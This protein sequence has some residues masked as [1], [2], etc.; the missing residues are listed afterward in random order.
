M[1][2]LEKEG[3][4]ARRLRALEEE[5]RLVRQS[6]KDISRRM[7]KLERGQPVELPEPRTAPWRGAPEPIVPESLQPVEPIQ[8]P[9]HEP[10]PTSIPP[11]GGRRPAAR[12]SDRFANYF[13]GHFQR[14]AVRPLN[15]ERRV[16]RN[17]AIFMLIF[18]ALVG[19]LVYRMIF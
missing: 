3:A 5:E 10:L 1:P 13:A 6:L 15:R 12:E 16:Q 2:R 8:Q 18:V 19:Y 7:R 14:G 17:K 9:I 4:L 11:P